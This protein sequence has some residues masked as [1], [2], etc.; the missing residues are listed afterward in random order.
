MQ[1]DRLGDA[2]K[3]GCIGGFIGLTTFLAGTLLLTNVLDEQTYIKL[4][5]I[6]AVGVRVVGL[7]TTNNQISEQAKYGF[8]TGMVAAA[9]LFAYGLSGDGTNTQGAEKG[10]VT[11][12][13][14][15]L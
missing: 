3:I 10:H 8:I 15:R 13:L 2:Y 9:G 1:P 14:K 4:A 5:L 11:H 6:T 12:A 7:N